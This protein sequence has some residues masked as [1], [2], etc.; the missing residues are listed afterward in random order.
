MTLDRIAGE[1]GVSLSSVRLWVRDIEI[2]RSLVEM[3]RRRSSRRRGERWRERRREARRAFQEQGRT[4]ARLGEPLHTAGCML[5]WAEGKKNRN[6]VQFSNSDPAMHSVFVGFLRTCF[7]TPDEQLRF[8]V[9]AYTSGTRAIEAIEAYWLD[10]LQ[11]PPE[12]ARKHT[13]N[14]P[15][16]SSSGNKAGKLPNGVCTLAVAKSTWLVQHIYGAIQE[17]SGIDQPQWLDCRH[18]N[19]SSR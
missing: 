1:L 12:S 11:L 2:P 14:H 3:N 17:Y 15:P 7:A 16:T 18:S 10:L 5:Y 19:Q 13:V 8:S 4:R 6:T 9:N